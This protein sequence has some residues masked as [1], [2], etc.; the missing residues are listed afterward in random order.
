MGLVIFGSMFVPLFALGCASSPTRPKYPPSFDRGAVAA[1]LGSVDVRTC[2]VAGGPT[3]SG[4][5]R[6]VFN[7]DG[8]VLS[9]NVD[10]PPFAGT[11]VGT[12]IERRFMALRIPSFQGRDP[13]PVGK[14]FFIER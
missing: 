13:L 9:A 5:L 3:G 7:P 10:Q 6:V 12:C 11:P 4:H 14:S 8:S 1:A 2:K